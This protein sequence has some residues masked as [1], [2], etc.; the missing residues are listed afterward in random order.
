MDTKS[1]VLEIADLA[2]ELDLPTSDLVVA[3]LTLAS[4]YGL[5]IASKNSLD[6][7]EH[8]FATELPTSEGVATV[9]ITYLPHD[10]INDLTIVH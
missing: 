4:E 3:C 1:L 6:L 2:R 8:G 9:T 7:T 10:V 5:Q